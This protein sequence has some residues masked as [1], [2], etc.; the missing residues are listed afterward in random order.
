MN[1]EE[2][3]KYYKEEIAEIGEENFCEECDEGLLE[4]ISAEEW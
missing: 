1:C 4:E 3:R 2:C